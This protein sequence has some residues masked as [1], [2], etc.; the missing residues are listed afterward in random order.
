MLVFIFKNT[1]FQIGEKFA[2]VGPSG[3][4]IITPSICLYNMSLYKNCP[5]V[6]NLSNLMNIS[7]FIND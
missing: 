1:V 6:T 3:D 7:F 4:P 5:C 2:I